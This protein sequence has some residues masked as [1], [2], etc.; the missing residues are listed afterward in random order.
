MLPAPAP[1]IAPLPQATLPK[2]VEHALSLTSTPPGAH[3]FRGGVEI[4]VAPATISLPESSTPVSFVA[5]F[6]DGRE[7]TQTIVP[8]RAHAELAF[9]APPKPVQTVP[10]QPPTK[11]TPK[12]PT[13]PVDRDAP[14]DPFKK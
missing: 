5:K 12:Q 11:Q 9:V 13:G 14:L 10:K 2:P 8:D 4:G 3:L 7:V 6:D 1:R